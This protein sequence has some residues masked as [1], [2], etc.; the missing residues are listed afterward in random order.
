MVLV[1]GVPLVQKEYQSVIDAFKKLSRARGIGK[2][3][4]GA[5]IQ[6][7]LSF[8]DKPYGVPAIKSPF[9]GAPLIIPESFDEYE[10]VDTL[11]PKEQKLIEIINKEQAEGRNC[12][13]YA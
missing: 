1:K 11:L 9:N 3:M 10:D 2:A 6:F 5:M 13:V 7:S 4:L 12:F 8:L